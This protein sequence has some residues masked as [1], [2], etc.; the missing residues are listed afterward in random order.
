MEHL[1]FFIGNTFTVKVNKYVQCVDKGCHT[2]VTPNPGDEGILNNNP[3]YKH[4]MVLSRYKIT[5]NA[6]FLLTYKDDGKTQI[7]FILFD[8]TL[9]NLL[10]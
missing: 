1:Q 7:T 8:Q 4:K 3:T 9:V 5:I 10:T 6:K 2:K